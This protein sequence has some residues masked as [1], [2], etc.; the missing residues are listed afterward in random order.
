MNKKSIEKHLISIL[1]KDVRNIISN[2][3]KQMITPL[4]NIIN[5]IV[6]T[7]GAIASL[8]MEEK[9]NDYDLYFRDIKI[10]QDCLHSILTKYKIPGHTAVVLRD[11]PHCNWKIPNTNETLAVAPGRLKIVDGI[12]KDDI[13]ISNCYYGK[14]V[15]YDPIEALIDISVT[16]NAISLK[17][18]QFIIRLIGA[19]LD[20]H[21]TFDFV[22]C[23]N[24]YAYETGLVLNKFALESIM[25]KE[26]Q[27]M[28]SPTP[29][30]TIIRMK[31]FI[32]RG[33][34]IKNSEILKILYDVAALGIKDPEK[35]LANLGDPFI[36]QKLIG[37]SF[38]D[39]K[40]IFDALDKD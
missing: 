36:K 6:I 9:P 20:I 1:S 38:S 21:K 28:G 29:M 30:D 12:T 35:M 40:E 33:W 2:N 15:E 25:F 16:E 37:I 13:L 24:Y 26:L 34:S 17:E 19:P 11:P 27:Y 5:N 31:K 7:G 18:F 4:D 3:K 23:I 14:S 8:L 32:S 39:R 22:H 10:A